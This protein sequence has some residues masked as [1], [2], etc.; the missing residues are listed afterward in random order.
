ML[1]ISTD[2]ADRMS[3]LKQALARL[4][5]ARVAEL[6]RRGGARHKVALAARLEHAGGASS[7]ELRDISAGGGCVVGIPAG[8]AA[9]RLLVAGL[10]PVEIRVVASDEAGL[11]VNFVFASP[12]ESERMADAVARLTSA[13]RAA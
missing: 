4:L 5:H 8:V 11:H 2:V 10:P 7:G 3:E 13:R 6:D 12:D 1:A 9:G